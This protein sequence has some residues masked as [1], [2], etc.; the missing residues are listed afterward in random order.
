MSGLVQGSKNGGQHGARDGILAGGGESHVVESTSTASLTTHPVYEPWLAIAEIQHH[1]NK[2]G[3]RE[4]VQ[5]NHNYATRSPATAAGPYSTGGTVAAGGVSTFRTSRFGSQD[6]PILTTQ[7][8]HTAHRWSNPVV[9]TTPSNWL[10]STNDRSRQEIGEERQAGEQGWPHPSQPFH[11][12]SSP[13]LLST[14][15]RVFPLTDI[16][17]CH[18]SI[19]SQGGQQ[20][21][22]W[23]K[24]SSPSCRDNSG[25]EARERGRDE[26]GSCCPP[27]SW[28]GA[29]SAS[30]LRGCTLHRNVT[31]IF[32]LIISLK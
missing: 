23:T 17:P 2:K 11:G 31:K 5:H 18:D 29:W 8:G 4:A 15:L 25:G 19:G 6:Y 3:K 13:Q 1:R 26:K 20:S 24:H 16:T 9:R 14:C 30:Y 27:W 22:C 10:L 21:C 32:V 12:K 7:G 28:I